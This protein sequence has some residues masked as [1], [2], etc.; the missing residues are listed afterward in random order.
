[1]NKITLYAVDFSQNE[2]NDSSP[3]SC[4]KMPFLSKI[5]T[6]GD[7]E[8]TLAALEEMQKAT[9][10]DNRDKYLVDISKLPI[11]RTKSVENR[12]LDFIEAVGN[13]YLFRVDD[14]AVKVC[15]H[16]GGKSLTDAVASILS[17]S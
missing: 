3:K 14:V 10:A 15:F 6:G 16:P 5:Y 4:I 1:M 2:R 13:P 11:D 8:M 17:G 12:I 7:A 9:A